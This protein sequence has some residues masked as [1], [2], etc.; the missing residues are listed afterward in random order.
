[1]S[2]FFK[3][4]Q[5]RTVQVSRSSRLLRS[6]ASKQAIVTNS[7]SG[8]G[9]SYSGQMWTIRFEINLT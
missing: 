7:T 4:N 1:L 5:E 6:Q 9:V 3:Y 2:D 8:A